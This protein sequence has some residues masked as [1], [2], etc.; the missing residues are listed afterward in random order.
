MI[1]TNIKYNILDDPSK[2]YIEIYKITCIL[3]NKCY[4]GQAVSHILNHKRYRPHGMEGRLKQHISEA[5]SQKKNQSKYLNNAIKKYLPENFKVELL[6]TCLLN[7]GNI[8]EQEEIINNNSLYPYGY[9]LN[10]GGKQFIHTL[11]SRVRVSDGVVNY[12][13]DLKINRFKNIT[14][15]E[16]ENIENFIK[17]LNRFNIQYG[18]YVYIN[19]KKAD[20]G[21]IHIP[22]DVSKKKALEFINLIKDYQRNTLLRETP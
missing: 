5:Y 3:N 8:I 17:P 22:L 15:P 21:G 1:D 13:T 2:R 20:F 7:D 16:N 11:E 18:W 6:K 14:I 12:F 4:I 10:S 19:K 9:N